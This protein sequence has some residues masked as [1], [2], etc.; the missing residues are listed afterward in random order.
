MTESN[1]TLTEVSS[2]QR[3][4]GATAAAPL[5]CGR[6][7]AAERERQG[8]SVVDMAARLRLHPKQIAAIEAEELDRL[9]GGPFVRGFVRNYAKEL[10]LDPAPLLEALQARLTPMEAGAD[11][12]A[13]GTSQVARDA[14]REWVSRRVVM[15]GAVGALV[16]FGI[17]GWV[18]T[19]LT[20]TVQTRDQA[21]TGVPVERVAS[22]S[23]AATGAG[24]PAQRSASDAA[25]PA[26]LVEA[27]VTVAEPVAAAAASPIR[28]AF[29]ERAW[30]E[31]T[32]A[33]GRVLL[34]QNNDAGSEQTLDG[35]PPF[36]L[37]IGNASAV[38]LEY[39][40]RVI[41][42]KPLTSV[43]NVARVTLE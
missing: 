42:L 21:A 9:P 6:A 19:R 2:T 15:L 22:D 14:R 16:I 31:V 34:S 40:G 26:A 3:V 37:V 12:A 24:Q 18:S 25:M 36:K 4:D 10:R 43:E 41:D 5:S 13:A 28:L 17:I 1:E 38:T 33:D 35:K 23:A 29:R 20:P 30:V 11:S 8:I 7:L 27:P 32:Q 39:R